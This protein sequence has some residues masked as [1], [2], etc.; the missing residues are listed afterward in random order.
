MKALEM[1]ANSQE[2]SQ[3]NERKTNKEDSEMMMRSLDIMHKQ[4]TEFSVMFVELIKHGVRS[5]K[6]S[7]VFRQERLKYILT[8]SMSIFKWIKEFNPQNVNVENLQ[9]PTDL[10]T[11]HVHGEKLGQTVEDL[12]KI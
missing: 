10:K 9:L 12:L 1:K 6:E 5:G 3:L 7:E 4:L 8:N 11:L 2:V